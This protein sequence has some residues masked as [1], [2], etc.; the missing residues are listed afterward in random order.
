[1]IKY[2]FAY[3]SQQNIIDIQ[4]LSKESKR[5]EFTCLG[6]GHK[7]ITVLGEKRVKHFRH[8]VITEVNCSPETY[9]HKLMKAKFY[10]IYQSCLKNNKP[11]NI[12][13]SI[14]P[15]CDFY[16]DDFL[17]TCQL[18]SYKKEFDLTKFFK[19]I[20]IESREGSFIPD[21]LLESNKKE[22]IFFEVAVTHTSSQEKINSNYRIIEFIADSEK[23]IECIESCLLV[24][25]DKI[26]F[27]NFV[28]TQKSGW[29]KGKCHDGI[30][31]FA[32]ETLRYN[33]F[34]VYE[35]GKSAIVE[36]TL[37]EI[38]S[39]LPKLLH[40]EYVYY[41]KRL[42]GI[43]HFYKNIASYLYKIKVVEIHDIYIKIKNCFLCRYHAINKSW[44]KSGTIF[45]KFLKETGSSNMAAEC[46]YFRPDPEVFSQY[47]HSASCQQDV[48]T[49][50]QEKS[51]VQEGQHVNVQE[52]GYEWF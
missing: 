38:N 37:D 29:C 7:M 50:I 6:C 23:D 12:E 36:H 15:V 26:K 19:T 34:V 45:C 25:S 46:Q 1:M 21:I 44:D 2:K 3:D 24:E 31:P 47:K 13:I 14:N 28:R 39:L 18:D 16:E 33:S 5:D 52:D 40:F 20:Y 17:K 48:E 27:L 22:K 43:D 35:N 51:N 4:I 30:V 11:F 9:L 32:A 42:V 49:V 10:E 41:H 8:K